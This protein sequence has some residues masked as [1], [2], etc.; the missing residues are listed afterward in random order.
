MA[1]QKTDQ[2]VKITPQNNLAFI[3]EVAKYFM[4]FLETDFHKRRNPKRSIQL[5]NNSNLLVGLNLN[6][7]IS[8]NNLAWKTINSGFEKSI[9]KTVEKGVYRTNIPKNLI[10]LISLQLK[11]INTKQ[12]TKVLKEI[13]E[14]IEKNATLYKKEYDQALNNSIEESGKIIRKDLVLPFVDNLVKPI[15]NLNLGDENDIFIMEEELTTILVSLL[16]NKISEIVVVLLAGEKIDIAKQLKEVFDLD[17]VKTSIVSFFEN[18]QV[19]DLFSE[20]YEME[21][22]RMILDKQEFYFYFCDITFD[23]AKYPIFYIPFTINKQS[24]NLEIEFD[25]Q[26]YINKKAIEYIAQEYNKEKDL[27]GSIQSISERIIYLSQHQND[28]KDFINEILSEISN[29]FELDKHI[30][31]DKPDYQVAKSLLARISNACHIA[32]FDKSDEALVNDYEEIL[33]LITSDNNI[34]G[35]A[36]NKLIEDFIHKDPVKCNLDIMEEWNDTEVQDKLV[37][38][39]PIPLNEEQIQI[40]SAIKRDDCKYIIVQG[41]PGTGKSHTITAVVFNAILKNESVLVLSD[42]K[43]ALDVVED[44][45]TETM[46]KVRTDDNFQ[47]PVLRLGKTGNAYGKI[48]SP[49]SIKAITN[50]FLAVRKHY[51]DLEDNIDKSQNS[52]RDDIEAEIFTCK[53]V[54][55]KEIQEFANLENYFE[56]TGFPFDISEALENPESANQLEEVRSIFEN[57]KIKIENY[58][59]DFNPQ[60]KPSELLKKHVELAVDTLEKIHAHDEYLPLYN[61]KNEAVYLYENEIDFSL[62]G[63]SWSEIEYYENKML[64]QDAIYDF[65]DI[66]IPSKFSDISNL[67]SVLSFIKNCIEDLNFIFAQRLEALSLKANFSQFNYRQIQWFIDEYEK[68]KMPLV[69]FLFR[70][71]QVEGLNEKFRN[72]FAAE[73]VGSPQKIIENLK[74]VK[75]ILEQIES[76]KND[77]PVAI[78]TNDLI[79]ILVGLVRDNALQEELNSV[80]TLAS[81]Y[82]SEIDNLKKFD[83]FDAFYPQSIDD[84]KKISIAGDV[85]AAFKQYNII[86]SQ[87]KVAHNIFHRAKI[88]DFSD[89]I[90]T[91]TLLLEIDLLKKYFIFLGIIED[92]FEDIT[93]L[94]CVLNSYPKLS[95]QARI[96]TADLKT[97]TNNE[98]LEIDNLEYAKIVRYLSLKHKINSDFSKIPVLNYL[99]QKSNI[100]NLLTVQMTHVMDGRLVN[101]Y[102]EYAATAAKLKKIIQSKMRFPREEFLKLKEAFPCILAGIRDYAEYI[103]LEPEIFDLVIIDEASQVSIAQAF[104]ALLRAKKVLI[105]GD[106]K[107]FSNVKTSQARGDENKKYLNQL[108]DCFVRHVSNE[109]TKLVQL[110]KFN[111]KTSILEFFKSISNYDTQLQKHFRG[112]KEIISYSNKYFYKESLQVMKIRGKSIDDVIKFS[113]IKHDGK[114]ELVQKTNIPEAEFIISELKKFKEADIKQSVGIITPHTNQQK[115]LVEMINRLPEKDYFYDKLKL[116]IM[117]F[118]TCQGEER[119]IIFYSM[120]ATEEEDRLWGVFIKDLNAI[121]VE[122]DGKIKAQRLNVGLSRAK[123]CMHF[124]LSKPIEKYNGS[125]GEALRHYK[126]ALDEARKER[127]VSEV[128]KKSKMEPEVLNWFYQ[129][130]FYKNH[131]DDI[132]FLPQFE[133]GKYLKQLD[134]SYNHPKYKVDFLLVYKDESRKEHKIIIEYDGFQEHF[135]DLDEVNEFNYQ[136]YYVDDDVYREK[137]LESYGYKFLRINKFNIGKNPIETLGERIDALVKNGVSKSNFINHIHEQIEDLKNGNAKECPKCK[138]IRDAEDFKDNSLTTGYGRFCRYC[139]GRHSRRASRLKEHLCKICSSCQN[140]VKIDVETNKILSNCS[141][142]KYRR[143]VIDGSSESTIQADTDLRVCPKCGSKMIL[144]NGRHGKFYGCLRFPY[145]RGTRAY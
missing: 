62:G 46:N 102:N 109:S 85:V 28:F 31:V 78:E 35:E 70:G 137:V 83:W 69:G 100:E 25:S 73:E 16:E 59:F 96:N 94:I 124:I 93:Y 42:K 90:N 65:L 4:D 116:K 104:P 40:L 26:V 112:Y 128:D 115:I 44:K 29:F 41:P 43:E 39:S 91:E 92:N 5:R 111:I 81:R 143:G 27:K 56:K 54:D 7:Y 126:S 139:K 113:V 61:I 88:K 67:L 22:N 121:D 138:E 30:E 131:K 48:L 74:E 134:R 103:P 144:R 98:L 72:I 23:K 33:E 49:M 68:L 140:E 108:K 38:Q 122:E 117:T 87:F 58:E 86:C 101:F 114:A 13:S 120:V 37:F 79:K 80:F 45:I 99:S 63:K 15:E 60:T 130:K 77:V 107:Q 32:L 106:E 14:E 18:F 118:D 36:F 9:I 84:L 10:D 127:S 110:D 97:F 71:K 47:N 95:E 24:D 129:T 123:E 133:L 105:L 141:C 136:D 17:D 89:F 52:L 1:N 6:K 51:D 12:L 53:E 55:I 135:R 142:G 132:E 21:R 145:C 64:S 76:Y 34:L 82:N 3:K 20:I 125:I 8:F 2:G 11:K 19:G 66:A 119:D 57:I 75:L 50:N